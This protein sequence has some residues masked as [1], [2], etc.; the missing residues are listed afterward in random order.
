MAEVINI[1]PVIVG[2]KRIIPI[3]PY[4]L[5]KR[6][7]WNPGGPSQDTFLSQYLRQC[8]L[9]KFK[10]IV[11]RGLFLFVFLFESLRTLRCVFFFICKQYDVTR[12]FYPCLSCLDKYDK[13]TYRPVF[14]LFTLRWLGAKT[15]FQR[16]KTPIIIRFPL[17]NCENSNH[18]QGDT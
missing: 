2:S 1:D 14:Q 13:Y 5:V 18:R 6:S 15:S 12:A 10:Y 3:H 7:H 11:I 17:L 16:L 9:K 8:S 4:T